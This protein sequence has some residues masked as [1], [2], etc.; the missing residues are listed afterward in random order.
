LGQEPSPAE[1]NIY[2]HKQK[3][4]IVVLQGLARLKS[5]IVDVLGT[6]IIKSMIT[7]ARPLDTITVADII[8]FV[9]R[10]YGVT[11]RQ[12]IM[13]IKSQCNEKCI[14][15]ADFYLH[16]RRLVTNFEL[17]NE[18]DM[19]V[20]NFDQQEYLKTTTAHLPDVAIAIQDYVRKYPRLRQQTFEGMVMDVQAAIVNNVEVTRQQA[21]AYATVNTGIPNNNSK[22]DRLEAMVENLTNEIRQ[23][24]NNKAKVGGN[25]VIQEAPIINTTPVSDGQAPTAKPKKY[26]FHHGYNKTHAGLQCLVMKNN[27]TSTVDQINALGP[28]MINGV[29]GRT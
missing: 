20:S 24:K 9:A 3:E 21:Q 8:T 19:M 17:L 28:G 29:Q 5:V 1:V 23:L 2:I 10:I 27:G 26:C 12:D 13:Y 25:P 16:T 6:T 4:Y 14:H 22:M 18:N 11:T 15:E 7:S